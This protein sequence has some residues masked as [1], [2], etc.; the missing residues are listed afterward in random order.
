MVLFPYGLGTVFG[1]ILLGIAAFRS[2]QVPRWAAAI[3]GVTGPGFVIVD[4]IGVLGGVVTSLM[5]LIGL[6]GCGALAVVKTQGRTG[7]RPSK[8]SALKASRLEPSRGRRPRLAQAASA[9]GPWDVTTS[10]RPDRRHL[11]L[12]GDLDADQ[13]ATRLQRGVPGDAEVA[14]V[15]DNDP[16]TRCRRCRTGPRRRRRSRS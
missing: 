15:D 8:S 12:E 1:F 7:I 9:S 14:A 13:Y 5:L 3:L 4:G 6:L 11:E 2:G 16:T 10:G